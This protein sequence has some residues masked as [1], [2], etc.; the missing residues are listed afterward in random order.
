MSTTQNEHAEHR[1]P[2]LTYNHCGERHFG[3]CMIMCHKCAKIRHK[4]RYCRGKAVSTGANAQPVVTC[5]GCREKDT[6]G[7]VSKRG[8]IYKVRKLKARK[9]IDRGCQLF[10]VHVS[11]KEQKE[12]RLEDVLVIRA[13]LKVF[14]DDLPGL[15]PPR[16]VEFRIEL[17]PGA[18]LVARASTSHWG[19]PVLFV[20]KK[21]RSFRMCID[22]RE[23]NKL[24]VKNR[25][26]LP[27]IDDLF[28]QLQG[29]SVYSKID[30]RTGY[31]QLHI[32]E[33]DI[34]ITA[35]RTRKE[36]HGEHLKTILEL[37]KKEQLY[38]KFSKCDFWLES[39]QFLGHMIDSK[40]VHIDPAKIEAI[41]NWAAPIT[42]TQDKD[43]E[44]AFQLLKQKLCCA[45]I[46]P[47]PEGSKDF[48]VYCN[49]LL[50][51]F[52]AIL[53][54]REKIRYHP[55]KANVMADA[56]SQKEREPLRVRALNILGRLIK[57]I[58]EIR[59]D[60]T[61]YFDKRVWLQRKCL[62]CAKVKAEHQKSSGLLQQ[63]LDLGHCRSIDQVSTLSTS[64]DDR[65]DNK[66]ASRFWWSL[67]KALGTQLD[68][69][70][71][72]HP[73]TDS[74][75]ERTIQKLEDILMACMIDFGVLERVGPVAY[76]LEL[77]R[78]L[79]GI[80]NTFHI[81][82]LKKCLS[83]ESLIISLDEIQL[84]DKPHF[85]EEPVEIM[86][87]E[88]KQL[89]QSRIPIIKVVV[90]T[91]SS[92]LVRFDSLIR[93]YL[94]YYEDVGI[95]HE[96]SV[97]RTP[98]QNGV[99]ERQNRTLVEAA[100]TMLIYAKAPLFLWAEAVAIV[101]IPN[102]VHSVNQ[103]PE[104][105]SKW[106]KDHP[107]DNFIGN[108]SRPISTRHKLQTE[109]LLC[110]FDAFLSSVEPKSF[111]EALTESCWIKEEGI[112]FEEY[113]A[114]VARHEAIRIF[115]AFAGHMNM[116][117]YQMDVK[118][119]FLNGILCEVVYVSQPGGFVDPENPNH[120]YKLKKDLYGL[121]REGKYIL[122]VQIY[123]DDII[124]A[125]TKPDLC[126][127]NSEIMCSKFKMSMMGKV[128]F[129][130]G[131]QISQSPKGIFLNQSKYALE[132][133]KKYGMETSYPMDTPMVEKS[134]LDADP[135]GK[136]VDPTRY[137]GMI[138][139]FVYLT[140]SHPDL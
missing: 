3:H 114:L 8:T 2:P 137:H 74:Q 120:V 72:Y 99:V 69:S 31:H 101:V 63:R 103:P 118:T 5:Y 123:V 41:R 75:S 95:S 106:T 96:T 20:K 93:F 51:G 127:K 100:C 43:E 90:E 111:K 48:V 133:M 70:T 19:A 131:L 119:A 52:E 122:Q 135:Q 105:I 27:R 86:D 112:E 61:R 66:F 97:A 39:V 40:G 87:C 50:K 22:Y 109:S 12:K 130:L 115:L 26:P 18:A 129:F 110:Y 89:K 64:E 136:E 81:S 91:L 7:T 57:Q 34:P 46:L 16:Q 125:S 9:Y 44:E 49:A 68:M 82:N 6:R 33:E 21:D 10:V 88:V 62:T 132:I 36:E 45:P 14:P 54:Q 60:R 77:P 139:S 79:Q 11:E 25:Y 126:E 107:T 124:F 80:H 30:L 29:S 56:L 1:G 32:R 108:P 42:P 92:L 53:M 13:F 128:S 78:E 59:S 23:L 47:L 84:D 37:L 76:K 15:P 134:K 121:K 117:V 28:D 85:I 94:S 138:G 4:E 113:F 65:Q 35:F 67:Q 38:A 71:A 140:A 73:Q 102:N 24:T 98:Q 116:V 83:D 17:V 55:G 58:F 104:H